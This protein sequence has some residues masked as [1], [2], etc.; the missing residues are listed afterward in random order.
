MDKPRIKEIAVSAF[1]KVG[2]QHY[3][4]KIYSFHGYKDLTRGYDVGIEVYPHLE[5]LEGFD[6]YIYITQLIVTSANFTYC[7]GDQKTFDPG[8]KA[9]DGRCNKHYSVYRHTK[10]QS[11]NYCPTKSDNI[12]FVD[13]PRQELVSTLSKLTY[14]AVFE[15]YFQ[16][17]EGEKPFEGLKKLCV[18][19]WNLKFDAILR[20]SQWVIENQQNSSEKDIMGS[21]SERRDEDGIDP[22]KF[23][24]ISVLYEQFKK[25]N[26]E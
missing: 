20:N 26:Y 12:F 2:I 25:A 3:N 21:F 14:E 18:F 19:Q 22:S 13:A 7:D 11:S 1:N 17:S 23:D 5:Y 6:G 9:A 16:Y 10:G 15:T 4:D 8:K 24:E